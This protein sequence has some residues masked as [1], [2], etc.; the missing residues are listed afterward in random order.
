MNTLFKTPTISLTAEESALHV[1]EANQM[2]EIEYGTSKAVFHTDKI[3]LL[4]E[5]RQ[6]APTEIQ[7]DLEAYCN[8]NCSFCSYRKEDGYNNPM[9]KLIEAEPGKEYHEKKPIGKPTSEGRIPLEFG[10]LLIDW[11][12]ISILLTEKSDS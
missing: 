11:W 2:A 10:Q 4:Q 7:V 5:G 1:M 12:K 9:L 3:K 6:I 8:D